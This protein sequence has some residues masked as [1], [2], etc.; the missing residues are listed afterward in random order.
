[1]QLTQA[2][3]LTVNSLQNANPIVSAISL[4]SLAP[5]ARIYDKTTD[6]F[7][8]KENFAFKMSPMKTQ[9]PEEPLHQ[10]EFSLTKNRPDLRI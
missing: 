10:E 3:A 4:S 7:V 2:V 1:M 6:A 9:D 5:L 8:E